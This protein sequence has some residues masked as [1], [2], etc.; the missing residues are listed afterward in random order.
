M[1]LPF[2]TRKRYEAEL[3][4]LN[5]RVFDLERHFVTKRNEQGIVVETLADVP[6]DKR[7]DVKKAQRGKSWQQ[8]KALLELTDGGRR[9]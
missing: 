8:R 2:I 7:K 6:V 9:S 4:I 3:A 5:K 1:K